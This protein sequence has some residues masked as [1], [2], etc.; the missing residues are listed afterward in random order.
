[1]KMRK[2]Y[3]KSAKAIE[4]KVYTNNHLQKVLQEIESATLQ[5]KEEADAKNHQ[6]PKRKAKK[7]RNQQSQ[8]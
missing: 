2:R 4:Y 8:K 6:N 1:M 5:I 3:I 7:A